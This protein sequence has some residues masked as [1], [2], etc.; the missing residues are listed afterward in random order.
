MRADSVV[1]ADTVG[2]SHRQDLLSADLTPDAAVAVQL[3]QGDLAEYA[4]RQRAS[5]RC[6]TPYASPCAFLAPVEDTTE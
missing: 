5:S 6:I 2:G 3:G 4:V 1:D